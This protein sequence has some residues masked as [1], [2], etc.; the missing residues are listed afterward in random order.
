MLTIREA[1]ETDADAVWEMLRQVFEEGDSFP[2][3]ADTPREDALARWFGPH[4]RACV[5]C[6]DGRPVGTYSLKPNRPGRGSHVANCGYVV[7]RAHRGEGIGAALVEDSL[8][9]AR[10]QGYRAVQFNLVVSTNEAAVHL[11]QKLGFEIVARLPDAFRHRRL[12]LV[13]AYVMYRTL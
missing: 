9:R 4:A 6:L 5:A 12:G 8:E 11:Y 13:D 7:L 10:Q 3:E 1:T 2:S